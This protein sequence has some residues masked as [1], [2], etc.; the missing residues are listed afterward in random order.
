VKNVR[1]H[2]RGLTLVVTFKVVR[3][4]SIGLTA[5][6]RGHVV[7]QAK[8]RSMK[9]GNH[10]ISLRLNRKRWPT[11]LSFQIHEPGQSNGGGGGGGTGVI[12]TQ[13][14]GPHAR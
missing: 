1:S 2:L 11:A 4:A 12:T 13:W 10:S 6:R 5:K 7:A 9:P 3:K 8:P 14:V